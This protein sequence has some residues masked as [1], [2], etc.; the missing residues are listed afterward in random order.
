[1]T[2]TPIPY[3]MVVEA[4]PSPGDLSVVMRCPLCGAAGVSALP[5]F[6]VNN[7]GT[8]IVC[9]DSATHMARPEAGF[10]G[11]GIRF[12]CQDG[13]LFSYRFLFLNGS[14][15]SIKLSV[16]EPIMDVGI[17]MGCPM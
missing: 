10:G 4:D 8:H 3:K 14:G 9:A 6:V 11:V 12:A 5:V 16:D 15:V 13:H 1:M 17:Q 7:C 2:S